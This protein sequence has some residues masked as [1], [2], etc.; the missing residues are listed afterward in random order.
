MSIVPRRLFHLNARFEEARIG[1][2]DR[3]RHMK[4]VIAAFCLVGALTLSANAASDKATLDSRIQ[5][6]TSTITQIMNVPDK[7]IPDKI[8]QSATCLAVI[9]GM[10][11]GAFIF[12]AEYGRG[13]VTCR[14][15]KG[16]SA[17]VFITLG[18][19]SFGLQLGGQSTD[20]VLVAMN[21]KGFQDLL[22][23]KFKIGGDAAAAAGPVGRN[24]QASTDILLKAELLT[25]SRSRGLFAGI[26][27]TGTSVTQS[28]DD[29][30]AFYGAPHSFDDILHGNVPVPDDAKTFVRAVAKYF[31]SVQK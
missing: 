17:P 7:A 16:W 5:A 12:G 31:H 11:K 15:G 19:G 14:T 3:E 22:K 29:T 18:G 9:P 10:K 26:D 28:T 8:A 23:S 25:Y 30:N 24:T 20:V 21:D 6:A 13:V 27:L 1:G 2:R 4:K